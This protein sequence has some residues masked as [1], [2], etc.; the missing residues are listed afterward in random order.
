[1]ELPLYMQ[2]YQCSSLCASR[3]YLLVSG[4]KMCQE[5]CVLAT[6]VL[7][8]YQCQACGSGE[9]WIDVTSINSKVCSTSTLVDQ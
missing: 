7:S 1:M 9:C 8:S 4:K 6:P 5:S 3:L 2:L